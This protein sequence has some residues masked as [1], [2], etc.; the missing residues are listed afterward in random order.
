MWFICCRPNYSGPL[1]SLCHSC[2]MIWHLIQKCIAAIFSIYDFFQKRIFLNAQLF[3][4]L[5]CLDNDKMC[6]FVSLCIQLNLYLPELSFLGGVI[7]FLILVK[8]FCTKCWQHHRSQSLPKYIMYHLTP[9][10]V[11]LCVSAL[12]LFATLKNHIAGQSAYDEAPRAP[13]YWLAVAWPLF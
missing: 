2:I 4:K 5:G 7:F 8:V 9:V 3:L 6:L 11:L 12:P 13:F 1:P 10:V